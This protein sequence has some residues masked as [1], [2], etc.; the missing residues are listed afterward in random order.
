M[1]QSDSR[2]SS[3]RHA[4]EGPSSVRAVTFAIIAAHISRCGFENLLVV[5]VAA[6]D[7]ELEKQIGVVAA[8]CESDPQEAV[9][10]VRID[11]VRPV[12]GKRCVVAACHELVRTLGRRC[13]DGHFLFVGRTKFGSLRP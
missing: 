13:G 11:G 8:F 9:S 1:P 5:R 10:D 12:L 3:R 4:R 7:R 2:M 6:T